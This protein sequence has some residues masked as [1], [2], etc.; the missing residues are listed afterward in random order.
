MAQTT[1]D[2]LAANAFVEEEWKRMT[3]AKETESTERPETESTEKLETDQEEA[4]ETEPVTEIPETEAVPSGENAAA[5]ENQGN[6]EEQA[7]S[8]QVRSQQA[9]YTVKEGD[10]LADICRMYYG[11]DEKMEEICTF[12]GIDNPNHILPGQ[13]IKLP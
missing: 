4:K 7:A 3:E 5:M 10:T 8:S 6:D 13:K 9:F 12:N 2:A 1:E 11:T